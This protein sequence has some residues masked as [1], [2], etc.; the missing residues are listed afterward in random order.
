MDLVEGVMD[1]VELGDGNETTLQPL[2]VRCDR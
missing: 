2:P 1:S